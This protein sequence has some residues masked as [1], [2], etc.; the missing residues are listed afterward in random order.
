MLIQGLVFDYDNDGQGLQQRFIRAWRM[1]NK[2]DSKTLGTQEFHP[3]GA[4]PQVGTNPRS[5]S[6]DA[7]S[8]HSPGDH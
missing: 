4:L 1:L 7:L 5:N 8:F 6:Y 2:V 3:S